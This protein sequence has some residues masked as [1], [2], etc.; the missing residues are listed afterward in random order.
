MHNMIY[1]YNMHNL[2]FNSHVVFMICYFA[3][4]GIGWFPLEAK[5][6]DPWR[7]LRQTKSTNRYER[8]A[9]VT[10]LASKHHWNGK[11]I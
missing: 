4:Q 9:A 7:L 3:F 8:L 2:Y 6:D 5:R 11:D 10:T 1:Y